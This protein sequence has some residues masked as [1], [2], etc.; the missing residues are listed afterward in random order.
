MKFFKAFIVLTTFSATI[1]AAQDPISIADARKQDVGSVVTKVAGRVSANQEF[2]NTA[3]IQDKTAGIAV[4]NNAF[5]LGVNPGDSVIIENATITEFQGTTGQPGTGLLE[6][7]GQD[8]R[9][10]V[11]PTERIVPTPK[12]TTIPLVG[13]ALEGMLVKIRRVKFLETG[14]FQAEVNY[15]VLDQQGNDFQVRI[16]GATNI[17]T[18][19]LSIPTDY[20]DLVGCVSQFRGAYQVFPR[21]SEDVGLAPVQADTVS[22]S[23]TLDITSWNL[24]WYGTADTTK[25]PSDKA[26]QRRGIVQVMDSVRADL[27]AFQEV[28][29]DTAATMLA[30]SAQGKY[31]ALYTY[32]IPSEQKMCYVYNSET[33]TPIT[34]GLAVNGGSQAWA[35]GRFPYR[36]TFDA[37]ISG[38]RRRFVAFNIHGKAT[39]SATAEAD[40][41]RRKTDA[42]TFHAYLHDFYSD[43]SIIFV[44]DYN[45]MLTMSVV[46]SAFN[47][48]YEV[49]V[50]DSARWFSPT[51]AMEQQGL[52]S[53]IGFNRTFLDHCFISN[54]IKATLYR[55]YLESPQA[56]LSSYS[57]TISDHLPVT[58]RL[59]ASGITSVNDVTGRNVGNVRVSPMP[60][61]THGMVEIVLTDAGQLRVELVSNTGQSIEIVN[62]AYTPQIRLIQLPVAQLSS[63]IYSLVV[64]Q[65]IRVQSMPIIVAK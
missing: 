27:Y 50:N 35:N 40:Y 43:S 36:L 44:G 59:Y 41:N 3:Y 6:L 8:L 61:T 51:Y 15:T 12:I 62:E 49:F 26:R 38:L 23:R 42:E 58:T 2:R 57:S 22:K 16:D 30:D 18:N 24:E 45:D 13:E 46:D 7:A 19:S 65:G 4:F 34:S 29:S 17:A 20:I 55:T 53:Y 54:D 9:F 32:D 11:V 28:T 33:I 14:A 47:S 25:G 10:T 64:T 56:Y 5:K 37:T 21:F 39:D 31:K 63:G 52:A 1:A 48:P 60:L